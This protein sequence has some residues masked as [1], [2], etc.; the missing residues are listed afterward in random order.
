MTES[1]R[2]VS[3]GLIPPSFF[4]E[5]TRCGFGVTLERKKIW[6][7]G[8]GIL[9]ELDRVCRENN[10]TYFLFYGSLLGAVRHN[11]FIPWDDDIDV[12]MP[13]DDYNK[14]LDIAPK[15]FDNP[16]FLQTPYSDIGAYYS[17]AKLRNSNA[18]T[19][20]YG[21][22][23]AD[24]NQG[25]MVDIFPFDNCIM[26][27][28]ADRRA[29]IKERILDMSTYMRMTNPYLKEDD[30]R[31][32]LSWSGRDPI[33]VFEE[34]NLKAI[35]YN[36]IDTEYITPT[37]FTLYDVLKSVYYK[38]DFSD[39]VMVDFEGFK[40]PIPV[41]YERILSTLYGDYMSFPPVEDRGNHH[42]GLFNPDMPYKEY[43]KIIR[44][45]ERNKYLL[46]K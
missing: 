25:A 27:D 37:T 42:T 10:L 39:V 46:K 16:Y 30:K 13:R 8:L 40:F 32:I 33:T 19:I 1:E 4:E 18:S 41:G 23:Y 24:F 12:G 36:D 15:E 9:L 22:R 26:E 35:E 44:E 29:Y 34:I 45:E 38:E 2:L 43:L 17:Y 6:A 14:L 28:V 11:G 20:A 31:R 21:F 3:L 7:V 5:E